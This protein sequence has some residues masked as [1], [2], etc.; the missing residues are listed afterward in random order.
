MRWSETESAKRQR[1]LR[2]NRRA[3][4]GLPPLGVP[5]PKM[6]RAARRALR[7]ELVGL[8]HAQPHRLLCRSMPHRWFPTGKAGELCIRCRSVR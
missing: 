7:E 4:N 2:A 1:L 8:Q 5:I 3:A 6:S